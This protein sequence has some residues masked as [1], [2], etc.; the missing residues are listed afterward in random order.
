M[1]APQQQ[2]RPINQ[3]I[4]RHAGLANEIQLIIHI[5]SADKI[6]FLSIYN[7]DTPY[8]FVQGFMLPAAAQRAS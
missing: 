1:P 5:S 3:V 8:H 2:Q 7:L 6:S 4:E